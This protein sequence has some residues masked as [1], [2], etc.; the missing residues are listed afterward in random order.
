MA[1]VGHPITPAGH[2]WPSRQPSSGTQVE[3]QSV[4]FPEGE[5]DMLTDSASILGETYLTFTAASPM[6]A[7]LQTGGMQ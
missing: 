6:T 2:P 1:T 4:R 7:G 5:G 3:D